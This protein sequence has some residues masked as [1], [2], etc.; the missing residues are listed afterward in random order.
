MVRL[1]QATQSGSTN[2]TRHAS[3]N[4]LRRRTSAPSSTTTTSGT[5]VPAGR[6]PRSV[7][8]TCPS[9]CR[10]TRSSIGTTRRI[11]PITSKP[12]TS[13]TAHSTVTSA[14]HGALMRQPLLTGM[15][16]VSC[17]VRLR[18]MPEATADTT[19]KSA[20]AVSNV[21]ITAATATAGDVV[22]DQ[23]HVV[24]P[25]GAPTVTMPAMT[26]S[27]KLRRTVHQVILRGTLVPKHPHS[28]R[29]PR[30]KLT[31]T[32]RMK[33]TRSTVASAPTHAGAIPANRSRPRRTSPGG[34]QRATTGATTRGTT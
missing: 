22:P 7:A 13:T 14:I 33:T 2:T 26:S 11:K 30:S 10:S 23:V 24:R 21:G 28:T 32:T 18:A 4:T 27:D 6:P 8:E 29:R 34:S 25:G 17:T 20:T 1:P 31:T 9:A 3:S 19:M 15:A 5:I 12:R 16:N